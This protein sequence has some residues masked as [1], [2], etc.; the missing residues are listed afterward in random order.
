MNKNFKGYD[1][2]GQSKINRQDCK[3]TIVE[4]KNSNKNS[5][6]MSYRLPLLNRVN[7]IF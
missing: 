3:M 1:R 2:I 7:G 4:Y 6:D 5:M